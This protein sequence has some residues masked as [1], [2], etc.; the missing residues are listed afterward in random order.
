[1]NYTPGMPLP[2]KIENFA[3]VDQKRIREIDDALL[4]HQASCSTCRRDEE[5]FKVLYLLTFTEHHSD[6]ICSDCLD[7][8]KAIIDALPKPDPNVINADE[9]RSP[10]QKNVS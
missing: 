3:H 5:E 4:T 7:N 9:S 8:L 6:L 1:M 10:S 2:M